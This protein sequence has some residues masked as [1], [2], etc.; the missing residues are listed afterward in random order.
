MKSAVLL[1]FIL[2]SPWFQT[3]DLFSF[4]DH[5]KK[6]SVNT[7]SMAYIIEE[8]TK[9]YLEV[10]NSLIMRPMANL[11]KLLV[12]SDEREIN[13]ANK[14]LLKAMRQAEKKIGA[15][16]VAAEER[17][18]TNAKKRIMDMHSKLQSL[19]ATAVAEISNSVDL[20]NQQQQQ[21]GREPIRLNI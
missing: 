13:I 8:Q 2:L 4:S 16:V 18:E 9:V 3:L 7:I 11:Q 1:K 20:H 21:D 10:S 6:S 17:F 12:L 14:K 15:I 5:L 19:Q